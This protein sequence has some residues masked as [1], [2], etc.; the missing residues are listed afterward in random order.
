MTIFF[1]LDDTLYDRDMLIVSGDVG[2]DKPAPAIFRMAQSFMG[3]SRGFMYFTIQSNL[4]LAAVCAAG[5]VLMLRGKALPRWRP[6]AKLSHALK[7]K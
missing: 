2:I 3:G 1:D 7:R 4:V 5:L 6:V